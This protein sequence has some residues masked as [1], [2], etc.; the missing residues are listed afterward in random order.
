MAITGEGKTRGTVS[1]TEIEATINQHVAFITP[2]TKNLL[3]NFL[4]DWLNANYYQIRHVSADWGSTK[5]AITC[6]DV[7]SY[8]LPLPP[9]NEQKEICEFVSSKS[10]M[11]DKLIIETKRSV[12][13]LNERRSAL[14]SAAVTGK[15]DVR[16]WQPPHDKAD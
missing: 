16:D 11:Y 9:I 12:D 15:I 6:G 4:H 1:I 3:A 8:P 5:A 13:I 10:S 14:I 7:R 2:R